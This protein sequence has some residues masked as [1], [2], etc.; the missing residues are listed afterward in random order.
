MLITIRKYKVGVEIKF[1]RKSTQDFHRLTILLLLLYYCSTEIEWSPT[2]YYKLKKSRHVSLEMLNWAYL[3]AR[4]ANQ[5]QAVRS[6]C[7]D[8]PLLMR[9]HLA[10][11]LHSSR[12][13]PFNLKKSDSRQTIYLL[14]SKTTN[15]AIGSLLILTKKQS[16]QTHEWTG[17]NLI[18]AQRYQDIDNWYC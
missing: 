16:P 10:R 18:F 15:Q 1:A 8:L 9:V 3:R 6:T 5:R 4:L 7:G 17:W 13:I 11:A 14:S 12:K 2:S